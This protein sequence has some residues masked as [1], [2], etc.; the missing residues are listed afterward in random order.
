MSEFEAQAR[1][2]IVRLGASFYQ[3][4]YTV[5]SAGNLSVRLTDGF[6]ITPTDACL[7]NLTI[8]SISKVDE[9]GKWLSGAKPSKTIALHR[10]IYAANPAVNGIA[11]THSTHLV[12][13]TL[14]GVWKANDILPPITPYQVMKVGHVPLVAYGLPGSDTVADDVAKLARTNIDL[15]AVMLERLGPVVWGTSL[16]S[17]CFALEELEETAKLFMLHPESTP[18]SDAAISE[19]NQRFG[20]RW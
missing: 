1:A 20:C 6:L 18:L 7:G 4:G 15:K 16:E 10:R 14:R 13:L 3:R 11:H 17:A 2:T 5:G 19:L 8:E 12:A 9:E